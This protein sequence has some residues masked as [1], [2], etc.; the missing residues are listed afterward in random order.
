MILNTQDHEQQVVETFA[1]HVDFCGE[2]FKEEILKK[3]L[4]LKGNDYKILTSFV[5]ELKQTESSE[6]VAM[7]QIYLDKK[8][9]V[10]KNEAQCER[11]EL[12]ILRWI[13]Q[14]RLRR[15]KGRYWN[16][17]K[18]YCAAKVKEKKSVKF[19]QDFYERGLKMRSIRHFKLFSQVAGNRMYKRRVEEKITIEV[20]AKVQEKKLQLE[21]LESMI[22][23][24]EEK[25]RIELRKKAILKNQCDQAYL[26]GVSAISQEA[27]KMSYSTLDD[28]YR[29]M[30]MPSYTRENI[31]QQMRTLNGPTTLTEQIH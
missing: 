11:N 1:E 26:R 22:R 31:Y 5:E 24:L 16:A 23:E 28:Y 20:Q 6:L 7:N 13:D 21:F 4:E 18:I 25:Y 10:R 8:F 27:L 2:P 17:F 19:C 9:H 3:V 29:G 15:A 30:K 14:W 12:I